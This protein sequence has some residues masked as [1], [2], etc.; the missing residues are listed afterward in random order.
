MN[1]IKEEFIDILGINLIYVLF[2]DIPFFA[3]LNF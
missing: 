3:I 1:K 2:L